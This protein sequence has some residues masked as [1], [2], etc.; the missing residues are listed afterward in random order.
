MIARGEPSRR[1]AR[2]RVA[3]KMELGLGRVARTLASQLRADGF[4]AFLDEGPRIWSPSGDRP[5]DEGIGRFIARL[6]GFGFTGQRFFDSLL[7]DPDVLHEMFSG[8]SA[9]HQFFHQ[10][11]VLLAYFLHGEQMIDQRV[12]PHLGMQEAEV[13][14][15]RRGAAKRPG[16]ELYIQIP[17]QKNKPVVGGFDIKIEILGHGQGAVEVHLQA[18]IHA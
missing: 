16:R 7:N 17:R 12:P 18:Q 11:Q 1:V 9:S 15:L 5:G 6:H 2:R 13:H 8:K 10:F 3:G 14:L 4:Q